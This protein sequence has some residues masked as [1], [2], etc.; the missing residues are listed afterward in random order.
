MKFF[1]ITHKSLIPKFKGLK[2][3]KFIIKYSTNSKPPLIMSIYVHVYIC[4][5][6]LRVNI[7]LKYR[8]TYQLSSIIIARIIRGWFHGLLSGS[9]NQTSFSFFCLFLFLSLVP[10][11]IFHSWL[12]V[13]TWKLNSLSLLSFFNFILWGPFCLINGWV[14]LTAANQ[15]DFVQM[16]LY[17]SWW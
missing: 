5:Y 11:N 2:R 7:W 15:H 1:T 12:D 17:I 9:F 6:S 16:L 4:M 8:G 3:R 10:H 14:E 13:I